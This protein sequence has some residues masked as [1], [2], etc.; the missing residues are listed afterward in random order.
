ME[1]YF[2]LNLKGTK[3]FSNNKKVFIKISTQT[4]KS[5]LNA[6]GKRNYNIIEN[7]REKILISKDGAKIK[8]SSLMDDVAFSKFVY[9]NSV[10]YNI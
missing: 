7:G 5:F 2:I 10:Y 6:V 9:I 1:I 3:V 4:S 8:E